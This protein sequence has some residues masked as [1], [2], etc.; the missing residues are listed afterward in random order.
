[1]RIRMIV[2]MSG[3]RHD[4]TQWPQPGVEFEVPDA[5][6]QALCG[7][8]IAVPVPEQRMTETRPAPADP[9]TETRG[10]DP[11]PWDDSAE[12][13]PPADAEPAVKRGPGRPRKVT[14]T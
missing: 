5:E 10:D 11:P 2:Q 4:G 3:P 13:P 12:D 8:G 1:M 9:H 14:E 7:S 6:G